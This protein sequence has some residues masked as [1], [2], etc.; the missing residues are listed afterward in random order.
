MS[1]VKLDEAQLLALVESYFSAVDRKDVESTLDCFALNA[2]F[3]IANHG[4]FYEGRV[5]QIRGM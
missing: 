5:I 1:S 3:C 2:L 4:I